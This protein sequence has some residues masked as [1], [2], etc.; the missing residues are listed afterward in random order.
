V[1]LT[2]VAAACTARPEP[3]PPLAARRVPGEWQSCPG[4]APAPA[5]PPKTRTVQQLATW[6]IAEHEARLRT[7]QALAEC[8]SRLDRLNVWIKAQPLTSG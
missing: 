3:A 4:P 1:A 8:A 2:L 5:L 7:E 6:G